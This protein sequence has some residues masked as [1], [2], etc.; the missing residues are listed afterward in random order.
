WT[1]ITKGTMPGPT[2]LSANV[3]Q[4]TANTLY[5]DN[6]FWYKTP[7]HPTAGFTVGFTY[8]V[9]TGAVADGVAFVVQSSPAGTA[10]IGGAANKLG[11]RGGNVTPSIALELNIYSSEGGAFD[12]N[13]AND[14]A[15]YSNP[16]APW[17]SLSSGHP[18]NF[19]IT[20]DGNLSL[21]A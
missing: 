11:Y 7:V 2:F 13:A 9:Q 14:S 6:A 3:L 20:Y 18:I 21:V 8:Q 16:G 15:I 12:V 19:T 5:Q 17:G 10:A 1:A 4:M